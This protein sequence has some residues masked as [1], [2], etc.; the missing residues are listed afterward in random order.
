V[1][2]HDPAS[3]ARA[4]KQM[5][6]WV[7]REDWNTI[8]PAYARCVRITRDQPE[9]YPVKPGS[10][11]EQAEHDLY[12]ALLQAESSSRATGSVDDF[13]NAFLPLIPAVN[14]F[15]DD[16]LVMDEDLALQHNRLGLVQRVAALADRAAD[17]SKLE[18]F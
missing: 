2:S 18:G 16:V 14:K 8:L 17:L 5:E 7:G 1:Q 9:M 4:V 11:A 15:F 12:A 10:F 3:A 13:L 6:T